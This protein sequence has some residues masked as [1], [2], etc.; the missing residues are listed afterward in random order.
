MTTQTL[1]LD[2]LLA[3]LGTPERLPALKGMRRGIERETLRIT[4]T[5]EL[6]QQD[7]PRALGSA[8]T[9]ANITTDYAEPLLEF[10][11]PATDSIDTLLEQLGDVHRTAMHQMGDER[12]WPLS[13][14]CFVG[15][16][17]SIRLA[18][19]GSSNIGRMKNLYRRGLKLRYGSLMQ[20]I[21]GVHFNF[22]MPE[23]FWCEWQALACKECCSQRFISEKYMGL[24][25][26]VYRFGWLVPYLFGASPAICASFLKGRETRLPFEKLGEGTLYLPYATSLRLSDLGYTNSAQAGLNISHDSLPAYVASL[27]RAIQ[28]HAP[29]FSRLGVKVDGEYRQLND[30][31]LQLENELYAPIRPKNTPRSGEKPSDALARRGIDYIELRTVDVNP[32]SPIGIEADQIRFFD[33]FLV[34]C[35]L[36]PS[37]LLGE[38][39]IAR[40]RRNQTRVVLEGRRPGLMLE[41]DGGEQ[42]LKEWGLSL[43]DELAKVATLLDASCGRRNRYAATL[44][45]LRPRLEDPELTL[46]ARLLRELKSENKDN[47]CLGRELAARYREQLLTTPL[48]Y[49]DEEY[50][51]AEARDSLQKQREIERGD[52]LSFD[53]FLADY[54]GQGVPVA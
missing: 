11:T 2:E 21:A 31:V 8:L 27:R 10:I 28:T 6:S 20:V 12:L 15:G 9:H 46:S 4:P 26:N 23:S 36:R 3:A 41:T 30:N 5:G 7:H 22:S 44:E 45:A 51:T 52:S 40:N 35:L 49:W 18:E 42:S 1:T 38:E 24:I 53:D 50:F 17:E 16:E 29:E 48:E 54:F 43:F 19:Y 33:L 14:P 32:F 34:W 37:P 13:M 39:E 47:A 25:R